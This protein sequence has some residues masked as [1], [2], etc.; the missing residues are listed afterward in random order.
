MNLWP[1]ERPWDLQGCLTPVQLVPNRTY[2]MV[3]RPELLGG[4]EAR[5]RGRLAADTR[6]PDTARAVSGPTARLAA[7]VTAAEA[8]VDRI[9]LE[10][11]QRVELVL[12][13]DRTPPGRF[14]LEGPAAV[15]LES[16]LTV[17]VDVPAGTDLGAPDPERAGVSVQ[18]ETAVLIPRLPGRLGP[19]Q[20]A[21]PQ[22][23]VPLA[24]GRVEPEGAPPLKLANVDEIMPRVASGD[25][26]IVVRF[27]ARLPG[28]SLRADARR[29]DA[30]FV[31]GVART[32]R[33]L[34]VKRVRYSDQDPGEAEFSVTLPSGFT[35][36]GSIGSAGRRDGQLLVVSSDGVY[37]GSGRL[38]I[39]S[40]LGSL[41]WASAVLLAGLG[42]LALLAMRRFGTG[43][44]W[45]QW[46]FGLIAGHDGQASISLFQI[47]LWTLVLMF[48][49]VYV[50]FRTEGLIAVTPEI[51]G[52][53]G[54]AGAG[55]V[56]GRWIAASRAPGAP[57]ATG[58]EVRPRFWAILDAGDRIDLYKLQLFIF[59][60]FSAAYVVWHVANDMAFPPLGTEL[61]LLM[62]VS[63]GTYVFAKLAEASPLQK[64]QV[65][66]A[67]LE[68][69]GKRVK[70]LE[71]EQK[72]LVEEKARIETQVAAEA[73]PVK[74]TGV[75][76]AFAPRLD[77]IAARLKA[78]EENPGASATG[79]LPAARKQV[80]EK[81]KEYDEQIKLAA[82]SP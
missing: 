72:S 21:L 62:G 29:F 79:E 69:F 12:S 81:R 48:A 23:V 33:S 9:E 37:L 50:M 28:A 35:S 65:L 24:L 31:T 8:R 7:T 27:V 26:G 20:V 68:I 3:V 34:E 52:L 41:V 5:F 25:A 64:A 53:V 59:T 18:R 70:D 78:V 40:P 74:R 36:W 56:L 51:M 1:V 14:L 22:T 13:A 43:R 60:V 42:G 46:A 67:E 77:A 17:A 47:L 61:L 49:L 2:T 32:A 73:D 58:A 15:V 55:S 76:Q 82:G 10:D 80:E 6:L 57:A 30:C 54:F 44:N 39:N 19:V 66:K 45:R 11:G 38:E 16:P 75:Q 63:N 4:A 71:A